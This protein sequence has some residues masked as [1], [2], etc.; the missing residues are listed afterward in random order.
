AGDLATGDGGPARGGRFNGMHDLARAP[1]GKLYIA[2]TFNNR[3]RLIA[4]GTITTFAG[5]GGNGGYGGDGGP[6]KEAVFN[7][8]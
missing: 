1:D 2:D 3:V 8:V 7:G 5:R 6:A 4:D